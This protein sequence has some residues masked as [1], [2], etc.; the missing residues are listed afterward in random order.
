MIPTRSLKIKKSYKLTH[1]WFT[2]LYLHHHITSGRIAFL[3]LMCKFQIKNSG[4]NPI[5]SSGDYHHWWLTLSCA[6]PST[7]SHPIFKISSPATLG[8]ISRCGP[9]HFPTFLFFFFLYLSYLHIFFQHVSFDESPKNMFIHYDATIFRI[10]SKYSFERSS[11]N[12][13]KMLRFKN[14]Y[15]RWKVYL[16]K[17]F[18]PLNTVKRL[19]Q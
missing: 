3:S 6:L 19:F 1:Y 12:K 11:L 13:E 10:F 7:K 5:T 18:L 8:T 16:P 9:W 17:V 2:G 15:I 4:I 14:L